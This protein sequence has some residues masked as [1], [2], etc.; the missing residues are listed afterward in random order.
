M[1]FSNTPILEK[2]DIPSLW[3]FGDPK[4]DDLCPVTLS[5]KNLK[6]LQ[7][8]GKDITYKVM[9]GANHNLL[10]K[11]GSIAPYIDFVFDWLASKW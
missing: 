6:D 8:D 7:S 4:L 10:L 9:V 2:L 11:D 1:N 5:V 3:I